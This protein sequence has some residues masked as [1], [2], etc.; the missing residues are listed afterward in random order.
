MTIF[1]QI[2]AYREVELLPTIL[3]CLATAKWPGDL[4]FGICWQTDEADQ[5]LG[6]F[7]G[8]PRFRIDRVRWQ[9]ARGLCWARARIQK[10][11]Q[12][13]DFTLQLDAHHRFAK[14]WDE[15]LLGMLEETGSRKPILGSYAGV[16]DPHFEGGRKLNVNPYKMVAIKFMPLGTIAFRPDGIRGWEELRR[17]VR[18][19]FVS[20]HFFFTLGQ[21]CEEYKYDPN[22]Y[23]AGDEISL[24]IRSFTL[25]YDL[26]HPHRL[27]VWHEYTRKDR[28]K[29]WGDHRNW[30]QLDIA[31]KR[32]VRKMLREEDNDCDLTDYD[33]G[34]VRGH[35]DYEVYAGIDFAKRWLS[36]GALHGEEPGGAMEN[37]KWLAPFLG[38]PPA[39]FPTGSMEKRLGGSHRRIAD[40]GRIARRAGMMKGFGNRW[41]NPGW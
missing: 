40:R 31:S 38:K 29:H 41:C 35:R 2:A 4:R 14:H 1:I 28:I 17:P 26:F 23:F 15:A 34:E 39:P 37:G 16:Y 32:R 21:H 13:E 19:R 24:S 12:G 3:D 10:L 25:G 18:A 20:G 6:P 36:P 27:L 33:L 7:L 11:Y 30:R 9:E 22:L 8:D 5:C